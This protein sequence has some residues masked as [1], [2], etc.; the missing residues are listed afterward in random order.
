MYNANSVWAR[1][2]RASRRVYLH[3]I[4]EYSAHDGQADI[5]RERIDGRTGL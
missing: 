3:M 2:S 5:L 4:R 1:P